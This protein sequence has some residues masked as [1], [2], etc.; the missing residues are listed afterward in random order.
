[1]VWKIQRGGPWG[2]NGGGSGQGNAIPELTAP[3]IWQEAIWNGCGESWWDL[4]EPGGKANSDQREQA[5]YRIYSTTKPEGGEASAY[6]EMYLLFA[7]CGMCT[8]SRTRPTKSF[9]RSLLR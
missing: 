6:A 8:V 9:S 7:Q 5:T 4:T 1:M 2:G 3:H